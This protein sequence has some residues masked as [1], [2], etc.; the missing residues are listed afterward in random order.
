MFVGH[1]KFSPGGWFVLIKNRLK[2]QHIKTFLD[3]DETIMSS[4][5]RP[6][7]RAL[8][9]LGHTNISGL[10]YCPFTEEPLCKI[11]C[12]ETLF[13]LSFIGLSGNSL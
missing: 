6:D 10:L 13:N 11:T 3:A 1:A 12:L 4:G 7:G 8:G 5:K 9:L 2:N